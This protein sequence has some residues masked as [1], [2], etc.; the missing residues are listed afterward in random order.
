MK[1]LIILDYFLTSRK[2]HDEAYDFSIAKEAV[3]Q[4]I[5]VEVWSPKRGGEQP[6]FL[7]QKLSSPFWEEK[8][9]FMMFLAGL[10]SIFEWRRLFRDELSDPQ[11]VVLIQSV[12]PLI[13]LFLLMGISGIKIRTKTIIILRRE[14]SFLGKMASF[15]ARRLYKKSIY[16][17]TD[18][19][20]IE[21]DLKSK[22]FVSAK[23]LPIP[24]LPVFETKDDNE[25]KVVGY[26]G[27][28]RFDKGF[29]LLPEIIESAPEFKFI[30][31]AYERKPSRYFKDNINRLR[32]L[33][34]RLIEKFI[35]Q[36]EYF[37]LFN[38]CSIILIPC[39]R[40]YYGMGTSGIFAEAA[41]LGKWIIV[42][43]NTWMSEQ[44][45]K[46]DKTVVLNS[47]DIPDV[48]RA[49]RSCVNKKDVTQ[50]KK[51]WRAFHSADNYIKIVQAL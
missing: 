16:F 39:R 33:N 38:H 43:D 40:E 20:L 49:I 18:S 51:K 23:T 30:V 26:F 17:L 34:V 9:K 21:A 28:A 27:G 41:A 35:S 32:K 12:R 4:N 2:G 15:L 8:S 1:K 31:H 3:K 22:G 24:H 13:M 11:T 45:K 10:G 25:E 29:D 36:E 47:L 7:K 14:L 6:S 42:P 44:K 5:D 50:Q 46:Y 37:S 19:E 48:L